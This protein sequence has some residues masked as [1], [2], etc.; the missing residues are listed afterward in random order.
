LIYGGVSVG[1][2]L[3]RKRFQHKIIQHKKCF[4]LSQEAL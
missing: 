2:I 3:K 1:D 4:I